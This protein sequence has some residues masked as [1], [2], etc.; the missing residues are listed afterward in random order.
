MN[1]FNHCQ[2]H[3]CGHSRTWRNYQGSMM[4][5]KDTNEHSTRQVHKEQDAQE[6]PKYKTSKHCY[7]DT[8]C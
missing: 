1:E 6:K 7:Y 3:P 5:K 4:T 8:L 2:E